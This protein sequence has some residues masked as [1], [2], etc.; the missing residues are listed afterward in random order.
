[1]KLHRLMLFGA[2]FF[3]F[4]AGAK[5]DLLED[6]RVVV[7]PASTPGGGGPPQSQIGD[8]EFVFTSPSG[9]SPGDSDCIIDGVPN[10]VCDFLN[11]SGQDWRTLEFSMSPGAQF[12]NTCLFFDVGFTRCEITQIGDAT[13][14][15]IFTF[16]G[17]E[18]IPNGTAF[19]VALEGWEPNTTF[20]VRANVPEPATITLLLTGLGALGAWSRSRSRNG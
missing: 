3:L 5:A 9:T 2:V 20:H 7:R 12:L 1:M 19:S 14:P 8:L 6:P 13:T 18:G 17:G 16:S 10:P 4:S 11:V 15:S